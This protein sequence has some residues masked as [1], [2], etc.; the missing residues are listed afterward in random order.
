MLINGFIKYRFTINKNTKKL[1]NNNFLYLNYKNFST[2]K[3]NKKIDLDKKTNLN[4]QSKNVSPEQLFDIDVI[5][6]EVFNLHSIIT[7]YKFIGKVDK[8][9]LVLDD[10]IVK[11][12]KNNKTEYIDLFV[13][14]KKY[15]KVLFL[16]SLIFLFSLSILIIFII[17][18]E[19][20]K[21]KLIKLFFLVL[22]FVII[23]FNNN[24]K[25]LNVRAYINKFSVSKDLKKVQIT[26]LFSKNYLTYYTNDIYL[27]SKNEYNNEKDII[28]FFIKDKEYILPLENTQKFNEELLPIVLRGY[29]VKL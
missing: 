23:G 1:F 4:N 25:K 24:Y 29:N 17:R 10:K 2:L 12:I 13:S 5:K 7:Y 21:S 14:D 3:T 28:S 16:K 6:P 27:I 11:R 26:K 8:D 15:F 20:V 22:L 19:I 18:N 9:S